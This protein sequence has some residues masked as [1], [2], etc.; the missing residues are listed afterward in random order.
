MNVP[1]HFRCEA[2]K[3]RLSV[4]TCVSQHRAA[5]TTDQKPSYA[6]KAYRASCADC[7]IGKAH[8]QGKPTPPELL[9]TT[10]TPAAAP[11]A[12]PPK[13][14]IACLK[15]FTPLQTRQRWCSP[16]CDP[17]W[18]QTENH[19]DDGDDDHRERMRDAGT[20]PPPADATEAPRHNQEEP[21]PRPTKQCKQ[22][23]KTYT[24]R[25]NAQV[26][27]SP[28]CKVASKGNPPRKAKESPALAKRAKPPRA[29]KPRAPT[30]AV[31]KREAF[32]LRESGT[33][34]VDVLTAAGFDVV[35]STQV[36]A[37]LMV[38]IKAA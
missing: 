28:E 21:M 6:Y 9:C 38:V 35:S 8:K 31:E 16:E 13:V 27:C 10:P 11:V 12:L 7:A 4:A 15:P 14:C 1:V 20:Q 30:T 5:N 3:A 18:V 23:D 33:L 37:G 24:P 32:E 22:C 17:E 26:F 2:L 29:P 34:A 36:P 25:G 19:T